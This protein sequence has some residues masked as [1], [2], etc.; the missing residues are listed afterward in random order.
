MREEG[1]NPIVIRPGEG[2][3]IDLGNFE[4]VVKA[5]GEET[6]AR[7]TVLEASE[8]P[9]F[10]PPMHIHRD[11]AESFY[12]LD[13]EYHIFVEDREYSCP[14]GS[15]IYIPAGLRHGFRVGDVPSRKLNI[16]T[17]A[18]MVGYFDELSR[19]IRS[20]RMDPDELDAIA[21]RS[22]MEITGPVSEG[23]L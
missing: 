22:G 18:A 21:L 15:F 14:A 16:Y 4:M 13:G 5:S 23:Y 12:V 1:R 9:G 19:A 6:D 20:G 8:P 7:L 11:A 17:P 3:R 2:R 10:G